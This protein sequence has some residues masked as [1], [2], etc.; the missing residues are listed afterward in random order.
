MDILELRWVR[1]GLGS[2]GVGIALGEDSPGVRQPWG[3]DGIGVRIAIE[4]R[5][6]VG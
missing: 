5:I 4:D 1:L 2:I 6:G 3:E